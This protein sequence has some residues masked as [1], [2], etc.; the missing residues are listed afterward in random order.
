MTASDFYYSTYEFAATAVGASS[1]DHFLSNRLSVGGSGSGGGGRREEGG[2]LAFPKTMRPL[3]NHPS[4]F[5]P[6]NNGPPSVVVV[7]LFAI[8]SR[9]R[10]VSRDAAPPPP[11]GKKKLPVAPPGGKLCKRPLPPKPSAAAAAA[12]SPRSLN[13]AEVLVKPEFS[14]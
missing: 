9:D 8:L 5:R 12:T 2:W 13:E 3:T 14:Y 4:V 1:D 11:A 10:I 6:S 7:S